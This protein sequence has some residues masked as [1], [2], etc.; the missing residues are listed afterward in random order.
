MLF[1]FNLSYNLSFTF[2]FVPCREIIDHLE[3]D[4]YTSLEEFEFHLRYEGDALPTSPGELEMKAA[5]LSEIAEK[6]ISLIDE[7]AVQGRC[8]LMCARLAAK[9]KKA[10][11]DVHACADGVILLHC[12]RLSEE[13]GDLKSK[14]GDAVREVE[15]E[16]K[17]LRVYR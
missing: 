13:F 5:F 11:G 8:N 1:G 6:A 15:S 3:E 4:E 12:S 9:A 14:F 7:W 16:Q 17:Q 2:S 10:L